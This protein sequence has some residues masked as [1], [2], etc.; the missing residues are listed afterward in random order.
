MKIKKHIGFY[1]IEKQKTYLVNN[2]FSSINLEII[3]FH[4]L[5]YKIFKIEFFNFYFRLPLRFIL[6]P[7]IFIYLYIRLNKYNSSVHEI[8]TFEDGIFANIIQRILRK[9]KFNFYQHGHRFFPKKNF[10]IKVLSKYFFWT[11]GK[12]LF[13]YKGNYFLYEFPDNYDKNNHNNKK[14]VID[15]DKCKGYLNHLSNNIIVNYLIVFLPSS[16]YLKL[17]NIKNEIIINSITHNVKIK[18]YN[19]ILFKYH[20]GDEKS[21]FFNFEKINTKYIL[22]FSSLNTCLIKYGLPSQAISFYNSSVKSDM[23]YLKVSCKVL[24]P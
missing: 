9:N 23:K 2:Y 24:N 22:D 1:I 3:D 11:F 4:P 17:K 13:T 19:F 20:P 14:I 10:L 7:I 18:K 12:P 21:E 16:S 8:H 5:V 6:Y 15:I